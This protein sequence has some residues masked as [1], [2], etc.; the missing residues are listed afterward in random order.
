MNRILAILAGTGV[1]ALL[2]GL[3]GWRVVQSLTRRSDAEVATAT[4]GTTPVEVMVVAP[5][6]LVDQAKVAGTLRALHEADV[7]A[8]VP[9]TVVA[10]L[11]DVGT[12]VSKGQALARL[13]DEQLALQVKQAEAGLAAA[14]AGRD[15]AARDFAGATSV[16][17]VGGVTD[18]QL[19][20]AKS[21]A[22][23]ADAQVQQAEAALGM[24]RAR[25]SDATLRAPF[26]GV[27]VRR[28]TD[29]GG[30]LNPGMPA[31]GVA[32]LSE[33]ELV[34]DVDEHVAA[35]LTPGDTVRISSDT[36]PSLPD[37]V[38]KTVSPMLDAAS[39]KAQVVVGMAY[40]VG[41]FGHG[42]AT[43][44]FR[45]GHAEGVIAVPTGAILDD[46]G[47][48]VVYLLEGTAAK[49][50]VITRG[51]RDGDWVEIHGIESGASVVITGNAYL[52][53]GSTVTVRAPS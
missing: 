22:L 40:V 32:D 50:T 4:A 48:Q 43:A 8:Q 34:L 9:G 5:R 3:T 51:L 44:T 1:L 24:A 36:V 46:R 18:A 27:V 7:S 12:R 37:G 49:R 42:G 35:G 33:L 19:V 20:A 39:H 14:E 15:S 11:A 28:S 38:V 23:G 17:Q 41:L 30:Q 47:E 6:D 29:I 26:A 10:V 45:L 52:S 2:C 31:F 21:R 16:A 13:D 25:L 53:D